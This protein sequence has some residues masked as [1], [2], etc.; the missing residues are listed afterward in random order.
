MI[1]PVNGKVVVENIDT[2]TTKS[3]IILQSEN[4]GKARIIAVAEDIDYLHPGDIVVVD[5]FIG[6]KYEKYR[7]LDEDDVFAILE[8]E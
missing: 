7:I 5:K 2:E 4:T 6:S 8:V 1:K 3:G